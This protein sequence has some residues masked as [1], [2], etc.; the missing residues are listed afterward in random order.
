MNLPII[1][2]FI[3]CLVWATTF[4]IIKS[5]TDHIDPFY[6]VFLRGTIATTGMFLYLFLFK[7]DLLKD[8]KSMKYGFILGLL[9]G[10]MY[11]LQTYGLRFTT[12]GHAAF[13]SATFTVMVPLILFLQFKEKIRKQGWFAI[14]VAMM[15]LFIFTYHPGEMS[16]GCG[17]IIAFIATIVGTYHMIYSG[18]FVKKNEFLPLIFYQFLFTTLFA[19]LA[20]SQTNTGDFSLDTNL[21]YAVF[22]LGL[23]GTLFCYFVCVWAQRSVSTIVIALIFALEPILASTSAYFFLG[24][25]FGIQEYIGG[26][27]ILIG[28]LLYDLKLK[29]S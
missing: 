5:I 1:L 28:V 24:E 12:S 22:Y 7:R 19:G 16:F 6:L 23:V 10:G 27:V 8:T 3:C 2:L 25:K 20:F 18:R 17:D 13:I 11:V 4:V 21:W 14:V 26:A 15:G 29:K 9:L